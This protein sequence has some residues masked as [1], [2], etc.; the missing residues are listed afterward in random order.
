MEVK[1]SET[2]ENDGMGINPL[3]HRTPQKIGGYLV[4]LYFVLFRS[5]LHAENA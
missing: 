2:A 4:L 1:S 5:V 3:L